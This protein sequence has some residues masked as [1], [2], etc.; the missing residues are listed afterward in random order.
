MGQ[1]GRSTHREVSKARSPSTI[2]LTGNSDY[3]TDIDNDICGHFVEVSNLMKENRKPLTDFERRN[4]SVL[5]HGN[6]EVM[7]NVI[8]DKI[9]SITHQPID[10]RL[11]YLD[12]NGKYRDGIDRGP[13]KKRLMEEWHK[14]LADR[15]AEMEHI[16]KLK[17]EWEGLSESEK[18]RRV[19]QR[20]AN[21]KLLSMFGA[22]LESTNDLATYEGEDLP[23]IYRRVSRW[24]ISDHGSVSGGPRSRETSYS[25]TDRPRLD[26]RENAH[27]AGR[28]PSIPA[29]SR[30]STTPYTDDSMSE[31]GFEEHNLNL[32]SPSRDSSLPASKLSGR[33][34]DRATILNQNNELRSRDDSYSGKNSWEPQEPR[35]YPLP[36]KR[37][38]PNRPLSTVI[39]RSHPPSQPSSSIRSRLQLPPSAIESPKPATSIA[40]EN[41]VVFDYAPEIALLGDL[42]ERDDFQDRWGAAAKFEKIKDASSKH[43]RVVMV[44][45]HEPVLFTSSAICERLFGG[46]IQEIQYHP[47]ER[48][49]LVVFLFPSEAESMVKHVKSIRENNAHEYRR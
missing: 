1:L 17:R 19:A 36:G 27:Y 42:P 29:I 10:E 44:R 48:I 21:T 33:I 22:G 20:Q 8:G 45:L 35:Q 41:T 40:S 24:T 26:L 6:M 5:Y 25:T 30:I 2:S 12:E 43:G 39:P 14:R 9:V 46:G 28:Q 47:A 32:Y 15:T 11:Q 18:A 3:V 49:A 13:I 16:G 4:E 31:A 38:R 34:S 7:K 37:K 23:E